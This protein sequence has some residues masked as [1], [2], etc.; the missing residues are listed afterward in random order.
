MFLQTHYNN[1]LAISRFSCAQQAALSVEFL[2]GIV[3]LY[4]T[5]KRIEMF[6]NALIE[7]IDV[8]IFLGTATVGYQ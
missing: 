7:Y 1:P 2:N 3:I 6:A 8:A 4:F 5:T